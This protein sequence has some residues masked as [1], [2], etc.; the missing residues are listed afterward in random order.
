MHYTLS[1]IGSHARFLN[2]LSFLFEY[3]PSRANL[4]HFRHG[5]GGLRSL[6]RVNISIDRKAKSVNELKNPI[7]D[8]FIENLRLEFAAPSLGIAREECHENEYM[9]DVMA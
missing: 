4:R 7:A 3:E 2:P 6:L 5:D 1:V 8:F 9:S